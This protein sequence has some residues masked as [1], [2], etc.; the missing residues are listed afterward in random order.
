MLIN[1]PHQRHL[2]H[3]HQTGA[4]LLESLVA[5]LVLAIG[6]LGL[7]G[8][9]LRNVTE[10]QTANHRQIAV[11]LADDLLERMKTNPLGWAATNQYTVG[12]G[13]APAA[14]VNCAAAACTG[15]QKA[16]WDLAQWKVVVAGTLPAGQATS[17]VSPAD[18]RQLGVMVAW[19]A[20][21]RSADADYVAPF[22]VSINDGG[23]VVTCPAGR[24]CH[25]AF[26]QPQ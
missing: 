24:V 26:G 11:R 16:A 5:L 15:A 10:N 3:A 14:A 8:V 13:A 25:L 19:R 23:T 6:V 18:A 12:W 9:Q 4:A 7:L 22:N 1:T 20:N 2:R 21:E 17:F